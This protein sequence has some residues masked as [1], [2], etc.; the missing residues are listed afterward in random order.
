MIARLND[1]PVIYRIVGLLI[2]LGCFTAGSTVYSNT[3]IAAI[4]GQFG[5]VIAGP[6]DAGRLF[7]EARQTIVAIDRSSLALAVA[8]TDAED[9]SLL[10]MVTKQQRLR[11]SLIDQAAPLIA[12]HDADLADLRRLAA[13]ADAACDAPLKFAAS[14]TSDGDDVKAAHRIEA[15]CEPGL[16]AV[17]TALDRLIQTVRAESH[18]AADDTRSTAD[19]T[20]TTTYLLVLAGLAVVLGIAIFFSRV[21]ITTPIAALEMAMRRLAS[22]DTTTVVP[23]VGRRDE[24]GSMAAAVQVFKDGMIAAAEVAKAREA[25][26]AAREHRAEALEALVH[27]F[28]E[29]IAVLV[30]ALTGAAGEM[31]TSSN[32]VAAAADRTSRQSSVVSAASQEAAANVQTVASATEELSASV[33][34]IGQQVANSRDIARAALAESEDT[35]KTVGSLSESAHRIGEVVQLISSIASQTNLLALNATIEAARAGEAGKGFAVV[36][37][38]VKS[39]ANQTEQATGDIKNQVEDIQSLTARTVTAIAHI[40][41]TIM[42]MSD[43]SVAIAAAIEEQA[44][45]TQEI[46]RSVAEAA[47]GTEEVSSNIRDVYDA[48]ESTGTAARNILDA[49]SSLAREAATLDTEVEFFI[50]GVKAA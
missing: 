41:Q 8:T 18:A 37:A 4:A 19:Q 17:A 1:L 28:E 3:Q 14:V 5:A 39:L 36:A 30:S 20:I 2:L 12:H 42:E 7:D 47:R 43:I 31:Q 23:G 49:A 45:A 16:D 10:A 9:A 34:E 27:V 44:A 50:S 6:V 11:D 33:R 35:R 38:E 48:S 22:L 21:S 24:I 26:Q 25:E 46:A 32:V 13:A 29:K 40:G 15:Q